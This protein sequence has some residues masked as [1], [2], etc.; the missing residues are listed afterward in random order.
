MRRQTKR[1]LTELLDTMREALALLDS[2][3][4]AGELSQA[5]ELLAGQQEA[6]VAVGNGIEASEGEG[7]KPVRLLE[8]YCEALWQANQEIEA[9]AVCDRTREPERLLGEARQALQ[10]LPEQLEI[11]FLPYKASMWDC[12]ESVWQAACADAGCAATV[13]PIPYFDIQDGQVGERHYEGDRFPA[14]VPIADYRQIPLEELQPDAIFVHNPFDRSNKVTSVLPQFYSEKLRTVTKRLIYIPYFVVNGGVYVTHRY[15]PSYENM[16][17]IVT[18][19]ESMTASFS[20][21][22]PREKFLP[23]G[24]PIADRII[25]LEREKPPIPEEWKSMLPNGKDFGGC[26]TV[27][28]NTSISLLMQERDRFLDKIEYVLEMA[29][30][31]R[32]I[33]LIWRPHPLLHTAA[34][35]LGERYEKRLQLLEEHFL[36]KKIGVL[37]KTPD[38]GVTVALSDAYLGE[39]ASSVITMFGIAGKPCFYLNLQIPRIEKRE[40]YSVTDCCKSEEAEYFLLDEPGWVLERKAGGELKPLFKIPAREYIRGRA[41]AGLKLREGQLW[42]YPENAQGAL[43]YEPASGRMWKSF[44]YTEPEE[45]GQGATES[46]VTQ[47]RN[48]SCVRAIRAERFLRRNAGREWYEDELHRP[49]DYFSFL[50]TSEERELAGNTGRYSQWLAH[51]DGSCGERILQAVKRSLCTLESDWGNP[52]DFRQW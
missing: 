3:V 48:S 13:M 26:R 39:A 25:R 36:E 47:E 2:A 42:L 41:Y 20:E 7:T 52:A 10:E 40:E 49:E 28:L 6:A 24:S 11:V 9:G 18:Q 23:L 17:F 16:D 27:M 33:L 14:Y 31:I 22:I 19:C 4:E 46:A 21:G 35:S 1:Q 44:G 5:V 34:A 32:G 12:M 8:C 43:V 51:M 29:G 38:V 45:K 15:L 37:D 30:K 50:L